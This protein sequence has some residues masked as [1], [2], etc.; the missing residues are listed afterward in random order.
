MEDL[1]L[2]FRKLLGLG[3]NSPQDTPI[4][5]DD[6]NNA[7]G[8]AGEKRKLSTSTHQLFTSYYDEHGVNSLLKPDLWV[9]LSSSGPMLTHTPAAIPD[10][11]AQV[12]I[13]SLFVA[14]CAL[15]TEV[16]EPNICR[17]TLRDLSS[18]AARALIFQL[19]QHK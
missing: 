9:V 15:A 4:S 2:F 1:S 6:K 11:Q 19:N 3:G 7:S 5:K 18:E 13:R 14:Q 12:E 8:Y 10:V 16:G 17:D